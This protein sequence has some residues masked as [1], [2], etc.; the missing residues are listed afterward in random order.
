L[1]IKNQLRR[2]GQAELLEP[3]VG[4]NGGLTRSFA[5]DYSLK[6]KQ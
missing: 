2:K 1:S 6:N 3:P 4:K 5:N